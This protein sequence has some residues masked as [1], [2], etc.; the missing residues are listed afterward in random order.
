MNIYSALARLRHL[1][2]TVECRIREY[3][4]I[5][6]ESDPLHD[7][8]TTVL[9]R[10]AHELELLSFDVMQHLLECEED[11]PDVSGERNAFLRA[12]ERTKELQA[13]YFAARQDRPRISSVKTLDDALQFE[14]VL[15]D[16]EMARDAAFQAW[17][18]G[19]ACL[20]DLTV[21]HLELTEDDVEF[22]RC[23]T[24]LAVADT[25]GQKIIMP[26]QS[27]LEEEK[28]HVQEREEVS[29]DEQAEYM[30]KR[31]TV[32]DAL[33][34]IPKS[35]DRSF[36]ASLLRAYENGAKQ[37]AVTFRRRMDFA[38]LLREEQ[39][40]YDRVI[41]EA[42]QILDKALNFK[43]DDVQQVAHP[44]K[45]MPSARR[46]SLV[47]VGT[48]LKSFDSNG[49][50]FDAG[51]EV[52]AQIT[53]RGAGGALGSSLMIGTDPYGN[54]GEFPADA[55]DI[56]RSCYR[57]PISVNVLAEIRDQL[58]AAP[59]KDTALQ[60]EFDE[61]FDFSG[62]VYD[63]R[64]CA[65]A[66][67]ILLQGKLYIC[68]ACMAFFSYFNDKTVFGSPTLIVLPWEDVIRLGKA[69]NVWIPNSIEVFTKTNTYFLTSFMERDS[70][71]K[72]LT[73]IHRMSQ[74]SRLP[75]IAIQEPIEMPPHLKGK[76]IDC[77]SFPASP[78]VVLDTLFVDCSK[79][80]F[81][82]NYFCSRNVEMQEWP[83]WS[84]SMERTIRF[85]L[86]VMGGNGKFGFKGV[87]CCTEQWKI[88]PLGNA[89]LVEVL[90]T[91]A[92]V[93]FSDIMSIKYYYRGV[94]IGDATALSV[95]AEVLWAGSCIFK[96]FIESRIY[97]DFNAVLRASPQG[98]FCLQ[99]AEA[100]K[101]TNAN[102]AKAGSDPGEGG[103]AEFNNAGSAA[104]AA[105]VSTSTQRARLHRARSVR[106]GVV[107][108]ARSGL[109][110]KLPLRT[111]PATGWRDFSL[112]N[113][114]IVLLSAWCF[115]LQCQLRFPV[116]CIPMNGEA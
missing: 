5:D 90:S 53:D 52:R 97:A 107:P 9:Q 66:K 68:D 100:V 99:A 78:S 69:S 84:P 35:A 49:V 86:P 103:V 44:T 105:P 71:Y 101:R 65:L 1:V 79:E 28:H 98:P 18:D 85:K 15:S 22:L 46:S 24:R 51:D 19:D 72:L 45:R 88:I 47:G 82:W 55:V 34:D 42:A 114:A 61:S 58:L 75:D 29:E 74:L 40:F 48:A 60:D 21:P 59:P 30:R 112:R 81:L 26:I 106:C 96:S 32:L 113:V 16:K 8:F 87:C 50:R 10:A 89:F 37:L 92:D 2:W 17:S 6:V 25:E 57:S 67:T 38:T 73:F 64:V 76:Y 3:A 27:L 63:W 56:E 36:V 41:Q 4:L 110:C 104:P 116:N 20:A 14:K 54:T 39:A 70:T 115:Y 31:L 111:G 33:G 108:V 80:G 43:W 77:G 62:R 102:D 109:A 83:E 93:P 91:M 11:V 94:T 7:A 13:I 95:D 23:S 12:I